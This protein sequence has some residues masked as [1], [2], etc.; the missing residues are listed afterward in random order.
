MI[1]ILNPNPALDRAAELP[2]FEAG[3]SHHLPATR[4]FAG[5]K[6]F[7]FA[8]ALLA[9]G[10]HPFVVGMLA[11]HIGRLVE[12][13]AA[14]E[15]I[16]AA[17]HWFEGETRIGLH[18]VD[19]ARRRVTEL[20]EVG[21]VPT[22]DDWTHY[23][24]LVESHL[25]GT[26]AIAVCGSLAASAPADLLRSLVETAHRAG[27][28]SLID[29]SGPQLASALQARPHLIKI[30]QHEA[31]DLLAQPVHTTPDGLAAALQVQRQG[32][33]AVVITLGAQGAVGVDEAGQPFAWAAP[34]VETLSPVGSGDSLFAGIAAA[35]VARRPLA[36]AARLGVAAGAANALQIGAGVFQPAQ[37][38]TLLP[39]VQPLS[40]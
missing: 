12:Q 2:G 32:A 17:Y 31:A 40:L 19:P 24:A 1:L 30:N 28:P 10:G 5:G 3:Q 23:S 4:W 27:V 26:Q 15:G 9:L 39:Q 33:R 36:E 21:P 25:P 34:R 22:P 6:G 16:P 14:A 38:E 35:W 18:L 29:T 11:G 7:N 20:Y 13:L 8:R 37:V